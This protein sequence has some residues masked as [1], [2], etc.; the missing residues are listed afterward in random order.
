M[1]R[2]GGLVDCGKRAGGGG[3]GGGGER[4]GRGGEEGAA[5]EG[6][7]EGE[8]KR[9]GGGKG[10]GGRCCCC[11]FRRSCSYSSSGSS[12]PQDGGGGP[13]VRPD[14]IT[15]NVLMDFA[16]EVGD[17][18][19]L[20]G[21][22]KA[23]GEAGFALDHYVIHSQMKAH[24]ARGH[25]QGVTDA[26]ERMEA[27]RIPPNERTFSVLVLA[28]LRC[29]Q[30]AQA[31]LLLRN[32]LSRQLYV[33]DSL[34]LAFIQHH[35]A[36]AAAAAADGDDHQDKDNGK[37]S[38][39]DDAAARPDLEAARAVFETFRARR[40]GQHHAGGGAGGALQRKWAVAV[41]NAWMGALAATGDVAAVQ[42]ALEA[43]ESQGGLRPTRTS[44]AQA[45]RAACVAGDTDAAMRW[46]G[47]LRQRRFSPDV[48]VYNWIIYACLAQPGPTRTAHL[49]EV[50]AAME[51]E[52]VAPNVV[53]QRAKAQIMGVLASRM[54]S[55]SDAFVGR[56]SVTLDKT[57]AGGAPGGGNAGREG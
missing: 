17:V 20:D 47:A 22:V 3:D 23:R 24:A 40:S 41:W 5:A 32:A 8:G 25:L 2:R 4:G 12:G 37:G 35:M 45:V 28:L 50:V 39:Q 43:M 13:P 52:G 18:G 48:R 44:Y 55:V 1:V 38:D 19:A 9:G 16:A 29:G 6:E 56:L 10:G 26:K 15:Y 30:A 49:A 53:T 27:L 46:L 33:H 14:S 11:C 57:K 54:R 31:T 51:R 21:V 42:E 34:F 7:G 36:P